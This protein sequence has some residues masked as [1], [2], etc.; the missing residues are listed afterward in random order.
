MRH[1]G[2]VTVAAIVS[3]LLAA[4][5]REQS[6]LVTLGEEAS[7]IDAITQILALGA[8]AILAIVV[9]LLAA[10]IFSPEY[11]QLIA[12]ERAIL[13]GGVAFPV[14]VLTALLLFGVTTTA[15]LRQTD[16]RAMR[17]HVEGKQ[18]WWRV[19]Y[20]G[21][22][23]RAIESANEIRIPVGR[24][25]EFVL[26]TGDVIH[27]FWVPNLAGK[28]DMIPGRTTRLQTV[29]NLAGE[30]RGQCAEFC[31]GAHGL[32]SLRV[33]AM[34]ADQF[35]QWV[36]SRISAVRDETT[37]GHKLFIAAGC[38][39]CHTIDGTSAKG[40]IGPNLTD[41]GARRA[42]AAETLPMTRE[43][44]ARWIAHSQSIKPENLMPEF[45]NLAEDELSLL[46]TYLE[47]LK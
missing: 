6:V 28:L 12:G 45:N 39:G 7:R 46:S 47:Q 24:T 8:F 36:R 33:V 18:W 21:V 16:E 10:A 44:L 15:G 2:F 37:A 9:A 22:A 1:T 27:S 32:M 23:E 5:S 29:A 38:G 25:V 14:V 31:G 11:R 19:R 13:Y 43:N 3:G 17:I 26:S 4:C 42:I 20:E 35:G 30:M 41:V 40:I 34:P